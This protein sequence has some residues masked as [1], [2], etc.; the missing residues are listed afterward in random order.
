MP[1]INRAQTHAARDILATIAS[2]KGANYA[3]IVRYNAT[4]IYVRKANRDRVA[5]AEMT[6][7]LAAL[8]AVYGVELE[9]PDY[10]KDVTSIT[11]ALGV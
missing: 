1:T 4:L 10:L 11:N 7:M 6:N 8:A 3:A 9:H 2:I 5:I